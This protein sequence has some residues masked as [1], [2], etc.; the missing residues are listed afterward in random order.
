MKNV[1]W[2]E[3]HARASSSLRAAKS[4]KTLSVTSGFPTSVA[5]ATTA[6]QWPAG[7]PR[8]RQPLTVE[9]DCSSALA[10]E[11]VP[12]RAAMIES[13]VIMEA[14]I[15]RTMR[16]SQGFA[17]RET[18]FREPRVQIPLMSTD[19]DI[20][21]RLIAVRESFGKSQTD[22]AAELHI[23]KNTLNGYETGER[24]LTM[25]TAKRIRE[26]F[27]VSTDWLLYGDIG[28]PSHDLIIGLGP[29]PLIKAATKKPERPGK[30]RKAS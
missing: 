15:V 26:R 10:T 25:E 12:P 8:V 17:K 24:S 16:T 6:A 9:T 21:R 20:A 2:L 3:H 29:R 5:K 13:D 7:I 14:N 1:I 18:T 22:F 4:A 19:K 23:A 30:R 11:P 28:Q 27:G